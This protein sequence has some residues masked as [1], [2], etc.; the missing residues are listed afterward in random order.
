RKLS[1]SLPHALVTL[2]CAHTEVGVRAVSVV[3]RRE[4]GEL[5]PLE[6][7]D[8]A[9]PVTAPRAHQHERF[10]RGH[11]EEPGGEA[12]LRAEGPETADDLHHRSLQKVATIFVAHRVTEELTL[13]MGFDRP[14]D[15]VEGCRVTIDCCIEDF[16]L[17]REGHSESF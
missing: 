17:N 5:F 6:P 7:L 1:E 8:E 3:H 11:T 4:H 14:K 9:S 13:D 12:R 15:V 2:P 16:A 10:V